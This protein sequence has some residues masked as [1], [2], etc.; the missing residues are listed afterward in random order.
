MKTEENKDILCQYR[1]TL[2]KAH[3]VEDRLGE[4]VQAIEEFDLASPNPSEAPVQCR[5]GLL[6]PAEILHRAGELADQLEQLMQQAA[7]ARDHVLTH[8]L[9]QSTDLA[10]YRKLREAY[11]DSVDDAG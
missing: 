11:V 7:A 8:I 6:S 10:E 9:R 5:E 4:Y 2:Q 3:Q 1:C